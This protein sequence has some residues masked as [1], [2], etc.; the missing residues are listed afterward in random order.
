MSL[1]DENNQAELWYSI[2]GIPAI[3]AL[4]EETFAF[5]NGSWLGPSLRKEI[6]E[7]RVLLYDHYTRT[8]RASDAR[9]VSVPQY[10]DSSTDYATVQHNI[11]ELGIDEWADRLVAAL[12]QCRS[13]K[14]VWSNAQLFSTMIGLANRQAAAAKTYCV[15]LSFYWGHRPEGRVDKEGLQIASRPCGCL[16]T[17]LLLLYSTP[18]LSSS[19]PSRICSSPPAQIQSQ[20]GNEPIPQVAI[21]TTES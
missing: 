14:Q 6:P 2:V 12:H 3:G 15:H 18:W 7:A 4:P 19:L 21:R 13:S 17:C 16:H 10:S 1:S 8:E 5:G 9:V 20:V 11:A